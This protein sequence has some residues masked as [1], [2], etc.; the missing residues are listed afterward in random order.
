MNKEEN[1]L[2]CQ[3]FDNTREPDCENEAEYEYYEKNSGLKIYLCKY[4]LDMALEQHYRPLKER[5]REQ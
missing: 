4:H 1:E 2:K 3:A 5:K